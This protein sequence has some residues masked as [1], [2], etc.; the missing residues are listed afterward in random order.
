[1]HIL[2][3][4]AL[5]S[6]TAIIAT[7]DLLDSELRE[8]R[9]VLLH[10]RDFAPDLSHSQVG[11]VSLSGRTPSPAAAYFMESLIQLAKDQAGSS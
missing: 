7:D 5:D 1:V 11:I 6:D 2:K 4:V 9:M 10:V 3:R 8:G